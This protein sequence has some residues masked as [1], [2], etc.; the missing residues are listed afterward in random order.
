MQLFIPSI[1]SLDISNTNAFGAYFLTLLATSVII[2]I[3]IPRRSSLFIPGFLG[4]P[5]VI[6]TT[7]ESFKSLG[8]EDPVIVASYQSS[9]V[10]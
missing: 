7:S 2:L 9:G 4:I 1:K 8:L 5:A 6:I 3:L 10:N